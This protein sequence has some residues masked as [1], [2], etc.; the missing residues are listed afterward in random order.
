MPPFQSRI[1][2]I[3]VTLIHLT[4][5]LTADQDPVVTDIA[6]ESNFQDNWF[7]R[8][9]R[10]RALVAADFDLD[11]TVDFFVGN[12]GD[13]SFVIRSQPELGPSDVR[14]EL[15]QV[16]V[17]GEVAVGASTA[18]YDNDGDY[19]IFIATG[20]IEGAGYC[21]LFQNQLME[22][23]TLSFV[24]VAALA[25]VRGAPSVIDGQPVASGYSNGVWGD[26]DRDGDVDLFVGNVGGSELNGRN[27]LWRNNGDGTFT[28][29][30][31]DV[32]LNST[33]ATTMH[34]TLFDA[35]NDGDLD[36]YETN[37]TGYN[38]LWRNLWVETGVLDF[39]D[40]TELY[41]AVGEDLGQPSGSF[42]SAA[43]DF[44][45]DGLQDL[46]VFRRGPT[47]FQPE[48]F[49]ETG[50]VLFLNQGPLG[51]KNVAW[52]VGLNNP[53]FEGAGVMG[54]QLGDINGDGTVDVYFGNGAP[55]GGETDYFFMS[56]SGPAQPG[57][58]P[59]YANKTYLIDYPAPQGPG[60]VYPTYP[61][62]THGTNMVDT[63]N[64]GVLELAVGNGGMNG[65]PTFAPNRLFKFQWETP[66]G[67]F[68]V[69]PVGDGHAVS[70]DA[71]GTRVTL[72]VS[73]NGGPVRKLHNTV[74]SGS[75]F[76]AQNG[77]ELYFGLAQAD[78]VHSVEILW[79]DGELQT[80][81][82]GLAVN[83]RWVVERN[84]PCVQPI[85]A[86]FRRGDCNVDGFFD[87]EDAVFLLLGIYTDGADSTCDD[88]CDV[89]DD[90]RLDVA[91]SIHAL[92]ALFSGG[93]TLAPPHTL[94]GSDPTD[95]SIGCALYQP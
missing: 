65:T 77:F 88:A 20:G 1:A 29:I 33:M 36:L 67:Y 58:T 9:R 42:A 22:T 54:C 64:D 86:N 75:A 47:D 79:P 39:V 35:D 71:T 34:P 73:E 63:D 87:I 27:V 69:R 56:D 30:T 17:D 4:S 8:Q 28:D 92:S 44:N 76:S 5:G 43:A 48:P 2:L 50:H 81:T 94:C 60:I 18:D 55:F 57:E 80:V 40:A 32:H 10:C 70:R 82:T 15:V 74:F 3:A 26:I 83:Q 12:P 14:Y 7:G 23:G 16:L 78:T 68:K 95:D 46:M 51:F 52:E 41:S 66:F 53:Y 24:D 59:S 11:G 21:F 62:R 13:E 49:Y 91:D 19:D 37:F 38:H 45:Q 90:G 72:T 84:Q 61:Y 93:T 85:G 25:G 89:N 31:A 6:L